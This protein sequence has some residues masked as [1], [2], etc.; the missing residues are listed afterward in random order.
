M[1]DIAML[2]H[3]ADNAIKLVIKGTHKK[4]VEWLVL[5]GW[6]P[7]GNIKTTMNPGEITSAFQQKIYNEKLEL[8]SRLF[9]IA[10]LCRN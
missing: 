3:P 2:Y 6:K 4:Q 7:V 8:Q 10:K 5:N 1:N 9:E